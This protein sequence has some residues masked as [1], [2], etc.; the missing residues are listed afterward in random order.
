[1]SNC[2]LGIEF[3]PDSIKLVEVGYGRRL[4]VFNFAIVD[5]RAIDPDRRVDQLN[6]TLQV[7][8]FEAKDAVVAV[9]AIQVE[10]KLLTLPPLSGRELRFVM[11]REAKKSAPAGATDTYWDYQ[12]LKSKEELGIKKR[13]ILLVTAATDAVSEAQEFFGRTRLKLQKVTTLGEALL[14]IGNALSAT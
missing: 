3:S 10:H 6:H 1:M 5:N 13:Q 11:Q 9:N 12:L 14:G 8:G 7:R 4:K 2:V